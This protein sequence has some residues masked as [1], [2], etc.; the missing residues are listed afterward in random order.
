MQKQLLTFVLNAFIFFCNAQGTLINLGTDAYHYVDRIDIKYGRIVPIEHTAD[1]SYFRGNPAKIAETLLLSNVKFKKV[2]QFQ[3]D[4]LKNENGE[5]LDSLKSKTKRPLWK[6]LY[7]EPASFVHVTSKKKNGF[8]IRFNPIIDLKMGVESEDKRF[9]FQRAVGLEVRGNIKRV[10]SFYFNAT[11]NSARLP[12]YV[13]DKAVDRRYASPYSNVPSVP[14]SNNDSVNDRPTD[15]LYVPG[16]AYWKDYSSKIFKF[17]DGLD[18]FDARG[19]VNLYILKHINLTFGRDKFFIGN[20]QRSVFLSDNAAPYLFLRMNVNIWRFNYTNIFAEL[21]NQYVRATDILLPKKYM[22]VHHLSIQATHWLNIGLFEAVIM[23]RSK[24]F[25]LQYLNPIIFYRAVE[26]SLGSPDNVLIGADFKA[27]AAGHLSFYGQ[28]VLD[29]FNFKEMTKRSGWWANKWAL[30]VGVKYIDI[31]PNLDAQFEFNAVRPFTYTHGG[32][33]D[34]TSV[35]F[36]HHNQPLAHPLGANFYEFIFNL[37]YQPHP[38]FTVNAKLMVARVGGDSLAYDSQAGKYSITHYGSDIFRATSG[39]AS[40]TQEYNNKIA[41]GVRGTISYLQLL[42]SYQ[43]W[44]NIYVDAEVMYRGKSGKKTQN[45]V[46]AGLVQNHSTFM[47]TIGLRMNIA[48][49]SYAF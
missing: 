35:N 21:T 23:S 41:Q 37:R 15:Y 34:G 48:Y 39:G 44:H 16:S 20:G 29:E 36:T 30:Q 14:Y 46:A 8:D 10:F 24:H 27:N 32:N 1:K 22:A 6:V 26:H 43:P 42:A 19:Y 13:T 47:F 33:A 49:R 5:W 18:Y 2:Q 9:V 45:P 7:R 11:G 3:I 28:F 38:Q 40:V 31:V 4:Y 12:K 17:N 25:E